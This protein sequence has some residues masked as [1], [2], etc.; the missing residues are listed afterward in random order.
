MLCASFLGWKMIASFIFGV[1]IDSGEN[2][3][4]LGFSLFYGALLSFLDFPQRSC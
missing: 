3:G 1:F 4:F 2:E